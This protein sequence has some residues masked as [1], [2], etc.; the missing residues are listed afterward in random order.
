MKSFPYSVRSGCRT[1]LT[2]I[3]FFAFSWQ[4]SGQLTGTKTIDQSG[5]GDYVSFTAAVNALES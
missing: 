3:L 1:T 2:L 5:T 4:V